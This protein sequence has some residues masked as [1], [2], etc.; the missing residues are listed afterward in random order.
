MDRGVF[1]VEVVDG[2]ELGLKSRWDLSGTV[3]V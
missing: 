3:L 1:R 2:I